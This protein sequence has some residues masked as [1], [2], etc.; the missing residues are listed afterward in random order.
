MIADS[1]DQI[2][3]EWLNAALAEA[4]H[5]L[6]V[7]DV[8]SKRI[9]TGQVGTTY[10]LELD[11]SPTSDGP[12]RLVAKLPAID[13]A[14][15]AGASYGYKSEVTFYRSVLPTVAVRAPRCWYVDITD[16]FQAFTLL[17]EDL[18]P[19]TPG[20][21]ADGCSLP[22]ARA[23]VANLAA[24]H[25]PRWEDPT[26]DELGLLQ[27][28]DTAD[29]VQLLQVDATDKLLD[30]LGER[31]PAADCET[32][33][34]A[35]QLVAGW[36][37]QH[38]RPRTVIHGDY[39]LDN[40]MFHPGG[41]V[42][43]LDWQT[44]TAAPG[45]RDVAYFLGNSLSVEMRRTHEKELVATYH[46]ELLRRGVAG[47]SLDRCIEDYGRGHLQGAMIATLGFLASQGERSERTDEMF[48]AMVTRSCAAIRDHGTLALAEGAL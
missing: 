39:R 47:Y 48:A 24:L 20:V 32:L 4:G 12:E 22:Q 14:S 36:L 33:R 13:P 42:I 15:R 16:D 38:N 7:T 1:I 37:T 40:L 19:A 3:P 44:V 5:D 27:F 45:P 9:G 11:H 25:A 34:A 26:L 43:A 31:V 6:A 17:L 2:T 29:F 18:D 23:A 41:D 10:L 35:A 30:H 46:D 21:Q 28:E 8:R